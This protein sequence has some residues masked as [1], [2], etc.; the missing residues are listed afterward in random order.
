MQLKE[1]ARPGPFPRQAMNGVY[2]KR[3]YVLECTEN[4]LGSYGK[5]I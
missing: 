3:L 5:A 4:T 2:A 1:A